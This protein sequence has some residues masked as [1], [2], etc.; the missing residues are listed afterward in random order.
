MIAATT[1]PASSK[2]SQSC[3]LCC[4]AVKL[5]KVYLLIGFCQRESPQKS[6]AHLHLAV[7]VIHGTQHFE[8]GSLAT[9]E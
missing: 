7:C 2:T 1:P 3:A 6:V 4:K 8:R 9:V 5:A